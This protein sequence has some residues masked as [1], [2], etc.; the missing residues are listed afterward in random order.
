MDQFRI[1]HNYINSIPVI[2]IEGDMT[3]ESEEDIFSAF[4]KIRAQEPVKKI[5]FDFSKTNYINSAGIA[6]LISVIETIQ[7]DEGIVVFSGL[8]NHFMKVMD[9]VGISDF[10]QIFDTVEQAVEK[11]T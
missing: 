2:F 8:S 6:T 1:T 4:D 10:A 7:K 5:I 3:S 11:T 9:I